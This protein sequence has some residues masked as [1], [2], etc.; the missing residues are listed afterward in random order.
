MIKMD[1]EKENMIYRTGDKVEELEILN[2][3]MK[4]KWQY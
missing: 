1:S 3:N 4:Q 2:E